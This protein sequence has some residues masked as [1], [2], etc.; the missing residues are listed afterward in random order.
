MNKAAW[1]FESWLS[2][3]FLKKLAAQQVYDLMVS[4]K[5]IQASGVLECAIDNGGVRNISFRLGKPLSGR[6][7]I[8]EILQLADIV[9]AWMPQSADR[10][11]AKSGPKDGEDP[12]KRLRERIQGV[13]SECNITPT[14]DRWLAVVEKADIFANSQGTNDFSGGSILTGM[15]AQIN[16]AFADVLRNKPLH[17]F[18][19]DCGGLRM[20]YEALGGDWTTLYRVPAEHQNNAVNCTKRLREVL[21]DRIQGAPFAVHSRVTERQRGTYAMVRPQ[22]YR[23]LE[24]ALRSDLKET[25]NSWSH[26]W[27]KH[28]GTFVYSMDNHGDSK[29]EIDGALEQL[30]SLIRDAF[31]PLVGSPTRNLVL[32]A[33]GTTIWVDFTDNGF[34]ATRFDSNDIMF[35]STAERLA[36]LGLDRIRNAFA[37]A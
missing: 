16:G 32:H 7:Q 18:T 37:A 34:W 1:N 24:R 15:V 6:E 12:L 30:L 26:I 4:I 33:Q 9:V 31:E 10:G 27:F 29:Q 20:G 25:E 35:R 8:S 23:Q 28:G 3:P 19:L 22:W 36:T 2:A 11:A 14:S 21:A 5:E 17:R 13:F